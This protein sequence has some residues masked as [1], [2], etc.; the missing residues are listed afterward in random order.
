M[1]REL[2]FH[3]ETD[4]EEPEVRIVKLPLQ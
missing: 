3:I 1:C 4:P 2:G